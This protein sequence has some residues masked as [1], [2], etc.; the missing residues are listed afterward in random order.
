M[1]LCKQYTSCLT[2]LLSV[3]LLIPDSVWAESAEAISLN[4]ALRLALEHNP[5]IIAS[6]REWEAAQ[7][8][9][10]QSKAL[11]NPE[12]ELE[13]E[14][15]SDV[16][17]FGEFEERNFGLTQRISVPLEWWYRLQAAR[18]DV[19][20]TRTAVF[21]MT[22]LDIATQ[23]KVTYNRV[24]LGQKVLEFSEQNLR[25]AQDF[26]DKSRRRLETGDVPQLEVLRAEVEVG[27]AA[28][29]VAAT[30]NALSGAK[31]E[32]NTLTGRDTDVAIEAIEELTYRPLGVDPD[33]LKKQALEQRPDWQG[34]EWAVAGATAR[35]RAAKAA[36]VPDLKVGL[37]R[38]TIRQPIG[39]DDFWRVDFG[40][41]VPLWAFY[42][43]RGRTAE[44]AAELGRL[45]AEQEARRN[46]ILQEVEIAVLDLRTA[47]EQVEMFQDH[48][49]LE[50]EE[51][52]RVANRSYKEGKATYLELLEAR[53]T[54]T[55]V[56]M[57]YAKVLFAHKE[58]LFALE[59]AVG[60]TIENSFTN[61]GESE[62]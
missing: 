23:V 29:Q 28:T 17:G 54:L 48:M 21:K 46:R 49:L 4:E 60:G 1:L 12:V 33:R 2:A 57:E 45:E 62:Q 3:A 15:M 40:L 8:R 14:G 9:W 26:L 38:Q 55:E 52:Y 35:R 27:R 32:L 16:F 39:R 53:R 6:Q 59:K 25:L 11:P 34:A 19:E 42:R 47:A 61:D 10:T 44:A 58:A 41:E 5:T 18:F 22:K 31:I 43:Q 7:A 37:F 13:F 56:R 51:A 50:V 24:L 36:V 30:R 20:M